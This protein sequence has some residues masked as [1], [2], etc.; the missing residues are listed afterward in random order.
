MNPSR[1]RRRLLRALLTVLVLAAAVGMIATVAEWS[2]RREAGMQVDE[3]RR[4][5]EIHTLGLRGAADRF[6]YLPDTISHQQDVL[7]ALAHPQD[8]TAIDRA[9]HY[10]EGVNRRAGS[11]ALYLI[12]TRG[13]TLAASNWRER[14]S[15]LGQ[16]YANRPYFID[17][18]A[19][20]NGRFYGVGQTT[21]EPGLF[22]SSPV[23]DAQAQ[24]I[25]VA[26]VKVSLREIQAAWASVRDPILLTD[27][28][29]IVFLG[30]VPDWTYRATRAL[31]GPELDSVHRQLQ[32]G[33]REAF[34]P[35]DWKTTPRSAGEPGYE[36]RATLAGQPR[37]FLAVDQ[38]L[39]DFGWTLT[40]TADRTPVAQARGRAWM[41][42]MLS[43]VALLLAGL[44]WRLR[45]R[46]F[47]EQRDI[48]RQL[49]VRVGERTRELDD[50]HAFRKAME[51]SLLVGMRAR[52]LE[53]R[54]VY[55]NPAFCAMTGYGAD[56][57]LGSLPPYP[58]WHPDNLDKHWRDYEA[59][60]AGRSVVSGF[61]SRIRHRDG[62]DVLTMIYTARLIDADGRHTGWMS[63]VV[64]ITQQKRD[65][66]RQR[67][68]DEQLWHAQR[69]ASLGEMALTLAHELNQP[70]MALSNF[71]S[72]AKAFAAQGQTVLL[73]QSLD[74]TMTQA[75]RT[76][77]I[78]K[79]IRGF[80]RQ[81]SIAAAED[82]A[83]A[84]RVA[85]ALALLRGE[86]RARQARVELRL[87]DDLP[88]VR[89]D[90]VLLEQVILNL[91]LN[92]LQA[93]DE[94]TTPAERRVVEI[95]AVREGS[96]VRLR[97]ADRGPGMSEAVAAQAFTPFFT[98]K[99]GGLGLGLNICRTIVES[100]RGTL[101]FA[102]R[103]GGG[104]VFTL[105]LE[106][107]PS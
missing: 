45:E 30:S 89:G 16:S 103:P 42:G 18:L 65:E 10:I 59:M 8:A 44:Y 46:R 100:H 27:A 94:G 70:L 79:R 51:D 36:I 53:G 20:R 90:S 75:Q 12:D 107:A 99:G 11:D 81:R 102:N 91:V 22:L 5:I 31:S 43:A 88:P 15:F 13:I 34:A 66:Q 73:N 77:E 62:H 50:A 57:L 83:I 21:G 7:A 96:R 37:R 72:A 41:L 64:D 68:S 76:A 80:V 26:V 63:S 98:T 78:V 17:A 29:G 93:M 55:V 19:G 14:V 49:E 23:R 58:Y 9:N 106:C 95:D 4:T 6:D 86:I 104:A 28:H 2:A 3:I 39:P 25:G 24:I 32:Y 87:P 74:E 85:S 47:A 56:E 33:Q 38:P 40:V 35:M 48:Q 52:D 92:S 97:V 82:C 84:P 69:L 54:I 60:M 71:A 1:R 101:S 61:E 67:E 105:E